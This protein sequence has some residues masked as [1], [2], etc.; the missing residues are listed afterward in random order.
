MLRLL[1]FY[2]D[3]EEATKIVDMIAPVIKEADDDYL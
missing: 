3:K 2:M 1:K